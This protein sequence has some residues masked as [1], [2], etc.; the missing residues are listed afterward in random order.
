MD[1][2][3]LRG[4]RKYTDAE[5]QIN[6]GHNNKSENLPQY[7]FHQLSKLCSFDQLLISPYLVAV[8]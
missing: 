7:Y 6:V 3:I 8:S 2:Q 5:T 4:R 1:H